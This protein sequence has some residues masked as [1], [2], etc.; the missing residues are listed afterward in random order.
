MPER[1][2][3]MQ[4]DIQQKNNP[5]IKGNRTRI[6][7]Q[8]YRHNRSSIYHNGTI[9]DKKADGNYSIRQKG[10]INE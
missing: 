6:K 1:K 5:N 9:I 4:S 3:P 10:C 7:E 8:D 2:N